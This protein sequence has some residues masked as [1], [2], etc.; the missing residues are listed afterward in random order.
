M[1][2]K[3][4]LLYSSWVYLTHIYIYICIV[5]E[6]AILDHYMSVAM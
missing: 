1:V 2:C 4:S 5:L 3:A 6:I